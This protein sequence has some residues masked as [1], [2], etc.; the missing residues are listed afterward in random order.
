MGRSV[1]H[2]ILFGFAVGAGSQALIG[3]KLIDPDI[4]MGDFLFPFVSFSVALILFE[5]G[6][7]VSAISNATVTVVLDK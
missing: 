1:T 6:M 5:G 2:K 7:T 3:A 4:L